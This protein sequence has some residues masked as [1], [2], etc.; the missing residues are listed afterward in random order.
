MKIATE[1][2]EIITVDVGG[3]CLRGTYH[4][5]PERLA[6]TASASE[7]Y[8]RIGILFPNSGVLP[9]AATG[10]SAVYWAD[11]FATYGYPSFRFDLE[12]LGDSDGTPPA[13][14]LD[15][16]ASVNVGSY[17]PQISAI[18]KNIAS[19]FDLSAVILMAHCAGTVSALY[20]AAASDE[21][22]GLILLDPYFHLQEFKVPRGHTEVR[23]NGLPSNANLPV[24]DCWN[25]L[26]S[27]GIPLL[28][29]T[30]PSFRTRGAGF[31]YVTY[32]Q[33]VSHDKGSI[34]VQAIEGTPHSFSEGPGKEG[35]RKCVQQWLH[36]RFSFLGSAG[37]EV[38]ED[39]P[40]EGVA[41]VI[42]S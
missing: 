24:I 6:L 28:V 11:S 29:L 15:F 33:T 5:S 18:A 38:F 41:T 4:R 20:A 2:R 3:L 26:V 12:G 40:R 16:L 8:R 19:R 35:V 34:F 7:G 22:K 17:A 36:S 32:L 42:L 10:D 14:V 21:V 9:R 30:A 31:D 13:R 23:G 25:Q 37:T 1:T 27:A 39:A